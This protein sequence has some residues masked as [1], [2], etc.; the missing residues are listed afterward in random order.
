ML[1]PLCEH[2]FSSS[3]PNRRSCCKFKVWSESSVTREYP[4]AWGDCIF[5]KTQKHT[6]ANGISMKVGRDPYC[7][8]IEEAG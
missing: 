7:V 2:I 1:L 4:V 5:P 8:R 6:K 3:S